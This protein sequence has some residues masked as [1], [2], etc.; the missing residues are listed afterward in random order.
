VGTVPAFASAREAMDMVHAALGWLAGADATAMGAGEQAR[1]LKMLEQA[2]S[3]GTA[4]RASVLAAFTSGQG[5]C[6]D[7][8]YS[9]RAWLIHKTRITKGAAVGH[10][11]W[12]RRTA[13]HPQVVHALAEGKMSESF[14]RTICQW[15][16]RLPEDCR[17]AADAILVTAAKAG[18]D[19][20]D[21]GGLAAEMY[22]RSR[23][24]IP[25]EDPDRAFEDRAV[26]LETTF[27]GAGV[28]GG[29]LTPEC[30]AVVGAVL[31]A[32]S[33]PAGTEDTRSHEQRYHD[34][35]QEAMRRLIAGG[36]LPERAGQPVKA[37]VHISLADLMMLEGSSALMQEWTA[38][39]RAQWAAHRAAASV[40]GSDGSAWLDG[41]AAAALAC[42]SSATP[43]VTGD[44]NPA[45]LEDLV[46]LCVQ[47][48]K[49]GR[50]H[51]GTAG[52]GTG[53]GAPGPDTARAWEA[54]EQAII[55]KAADLM[56][57]P[58]GLASFLR[59]RQLG[60]RLGGPSLPL[61]VGV[62]TDIPAAIRRAVIL[63]D[64]HCRFPGGCDQP[65]A[66]CEVHHLTH[67]ADGG[68]T[69]VTDC[70]LFCTFHHQVVIHQ[71]GWTVVLNPDGT[72]T[73]WNKDKSKVLHSH[74][75][76]VRP[77]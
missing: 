10:T 2:S 29:D 55:G 15:T 9:P 37:L 52:H 53:P 17:L 40:G 3:M 65:A 62:S 23:P 56:S 28:L 35:L 75:P 42:D 67:K 24:D 11:A 44:V 7:A 71:W 76:P 39:V 51:D 57:G 45:A 20:R 69:S 48:D 46:R 77:G 70:A 27:Q 47:L 54:L 32:L 31:D 66:A 49:L 14:G 25:D 73:A 30:A 4:A 34:G 61:D 26:R 72:T 5:Y 50:H 59:R 38:Q 6:A 41:D 68:K 60:V 22:E 33:A 1:C 19:L 16:D 36:L 21:L 63:R 43:V 74:G 18:M 8:D 58:G 13:A 12:A 64:Q